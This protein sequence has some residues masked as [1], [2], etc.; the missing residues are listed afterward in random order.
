MGKPA[1]TDRPCLTPLSHSF[2][3]DM[4]FSGSEPIS[5]EFVRQLGAAL[6]KH[7]FKT[8]KKKTRFARPGQAKFVTGLVVNERVQAPRELRRRLRA[9]FHRADREPSAC[10]DVSH[11]LLGWAS[12]VNSYDRKL[13]AKYLEIGRRVSGRVRG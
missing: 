5:T 9:M 1:A 7:G 11:L 8:N 6:R 3:L 10:A 12:F 4:T 2:T 13:G